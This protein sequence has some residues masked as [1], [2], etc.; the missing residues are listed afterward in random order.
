M[1]QSKP[2]SQ[3]EV[4]LNS[5]DNEITELST[6]RCKLEKDMQS[7]IAPY[8]L[9]TLQPPE[10]EQSATSTHNNNDDNGSSSSSS[11]SECHKSDI[12]RDI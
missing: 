5:F 11:S 12:P 2:K 10:G 6:K 8:L 7:I 1:Q 4:L 9:K 3:R